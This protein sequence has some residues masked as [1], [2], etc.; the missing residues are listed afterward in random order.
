M[1]GGGGRINDGFGHVAGTMIGTHSWTGPEHR[2]GQGPCRGDCVVL[3]RTKVEEYLITRQ[4]FIFN[5][6]KI[7]GLGSK[8]RKIHKRL[9]KNTIDNLL[10]V[11]K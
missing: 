2:L 10:L 4:S 6:R 11:F 8:N 3:M 7:I 9:I 1:R 5:I